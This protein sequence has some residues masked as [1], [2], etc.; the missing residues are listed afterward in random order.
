[1]WKAVHM[2]VPSLRKGI[3]E[4]ARLSGSWGP[5]LPHSVRQKV[6][7]SLTRP[8]EPLAG[9][10]SKRKYTCIVT[11]SLGFFTKLLYPHTALQQPK[12][13]PLMSSPDNNTVKQYKM[14]ITLQGGGLK[15]AVFS[16]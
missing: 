1:M 5:C 6:E 16:S 3:C 15:S 8:K 13:S 11:E 7:T 12:Y 10:N 9:E 14:A 2:G 4:L